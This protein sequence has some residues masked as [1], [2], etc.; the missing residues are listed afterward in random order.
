MPDAGMQWA[1]AEGER[2][3]RIRAEEM[4]QAWKARAES[5]EKGLNECAA[6]AEHKAERLGEVR[7][8]LWE[9]LL[10]IGALGK[11]W[12]LEGFDIPIEDAERI[13]AIACT[14]GDPNNDR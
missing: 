9:V 5:A 6:R 14:T 2:R 11:L 4:S 8:A 7:Q 3:L 13:V 10:A 12:E 1:E